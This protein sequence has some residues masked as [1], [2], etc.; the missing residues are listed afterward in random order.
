VTG[1][2]FSL[3]DF[4]LL[5]VSSPRFFSVF[6]SVHTFLD[7]KQIGIRR[8]PVMPPI[9]IAIIYNGFDKWQTTISENIKQGIS[10]ASRAGRTLPWFTASHAH[11]THMASLIGKINPVCEFFVY[12]VN[13]LRGDID[14]KKAI[15]V[16][17]LTPKENYISC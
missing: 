4:L 15:K 6:S 8:P 7:G 3:N 10:Y 17:F 5:T 11:G 2:F 9:K 1:K 16:R 13:S 12:R 14:A